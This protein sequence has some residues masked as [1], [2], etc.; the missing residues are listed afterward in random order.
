[1][2]DGAVLFIPTPKGSGTKNPGFRVKPE[3]K[4]AQPNTYDVFKVPDDFE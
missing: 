1:M 4:L 3:N 2:T